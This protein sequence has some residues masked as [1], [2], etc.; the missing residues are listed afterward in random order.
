MYGGN[1]Q[2]MTDSFTT[3]LICAVVVAVPLFFYIRSLR[4]KEALA[5][6]A[7][8]KWNL[9]S[10]GPKAQHPH[11]DTAHCI[12]CGT[13]TEVCPEGDVL[14]IFGGR[15]VIVNGHKCIGHGLCAEAC[16]V[17]AITMVMASPSMSAD[18]PFLTPE[19]E[20][21]VPNL[22]IVGELGGLA[23]IKN[24]VNQGRQCID[25]IAQRLKDAASAKSSPGVYDVLIVGAGPG[26][27]SASLR[28]I[29]H[30]L[31]Y[32]TIEQDEIGGTVAKYPRQK[33]VLTSPLEFPI[34]GKFKKTELSKDNLLTFWRTVMERA[35][36]KARTGEKVEDVRKEADGIFTAVT[37]KGR[38]R[39]R[40]VI[41]ALG[42]GGTP[43]KL[44]V[45]GEDL[46]KVMYR[47]IE[48][49][50]YTQ[51]KILVVGGGDSA[52][53]AAMGLA[54]QSGNAVTLSYRKEAFTRIKQRNAD[55]I[56][57]CMRNGKVR[58]L[59]NSVPVE[60]KSQTVVLSVSG[61]VEEVSNDYV[62]VF[63][64][65]TPPSDFLGKVGIQFGMRGVTL[66]AGHPA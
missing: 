43:R 6:E 32:V 25:T 44:G 23:L 59:F 51:Q 66:E 60:I 33:L 42:R 55:R 10:E 12:G 9:H 50:A 61:R 54:H 34:Y 38:Y 3:Y 7:A 27:I 36:F 20:T 64:G 47:L 2:T 41:L 65:G 30:R 46:P 28:A 4:R 40:A 21:S 19:Y 53:E 48:T 1:S 52:V 45:K 22:F 24:A 11:I 17:G 62:W 13:C 39:A 16:P 14:A 57:E 63:A 37:S 58:V 5:R 31:S 56:E 49:E 18:L 15:A 29:E 8:K 26:G 35:D